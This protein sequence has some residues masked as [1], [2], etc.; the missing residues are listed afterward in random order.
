MW[1]QKIYL[2]LFKPKDL[3]VF[4]YAYKSKRSNS[5]LKLYIFGSAMRKKWFLLINF[6]KSIMDK[7]E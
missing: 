4:N 6:E 2:D 3:F 5:C 1:L 7:I